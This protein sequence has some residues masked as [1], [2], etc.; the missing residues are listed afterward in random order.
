MLVRGPGFPAGAVV[1]APT[2]NID[3][4]PTI[5]A[6]AGATP[7]RVFD[8]IDLRDVVA[9]PAGY[10]GRGVFAESYFDTCFVGY[11]TADAVYIRYRYGEQE[12]Y[13][14]VADPYELDNVHGVPAYADLEASLSASVDAIVR[15]RC[16]SAPPGSSCGP[17]GWWWSSRAAVRR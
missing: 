6:L 7:G 14:L 13:D 11:R 4:A 8:G 17:A 16:R 2:G 1:T 10:T 9:D 3:V 15:T 12:M 5:S